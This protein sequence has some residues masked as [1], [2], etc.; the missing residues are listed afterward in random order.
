MKKK[1]NGFSFV[2]YVHF[3][4]DQKNHNVKLTTAFFMC[5][6]MYIIISQNGFKGYLS[7]SIAKSRIIIH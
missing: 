2:Y 4:C 6:K 5:E 7:V 3:L 1:G